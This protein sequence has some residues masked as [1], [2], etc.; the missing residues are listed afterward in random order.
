MS[1]N[2]NQIFPIETL[3][4]ISENVDDIDDFDELSDAFPWTLDLLC[5]HGYVIIDCSGDN[6]LSE[7]L[8][9][10]CLISKSNY[11]HIGPNIEH[12]IA[13]K[14]KYHQLVKDSRL[15]FIFQCFWETVRFL[16]DL[17]L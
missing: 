14:Q 1:R 16:I 4:K 6:Q 11:I 12:T 13:M 15:Y 2:N 5:Y 9:Q 17:L 10:S 7:L 3:N 8:I